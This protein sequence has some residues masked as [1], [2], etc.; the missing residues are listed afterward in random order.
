[1]NIIDAIYPR[2]LRPAALFVGLLVYVTF[3][4]MLWQ[5]GYLRLSE[6]AYIQVMV[7][8]VTGFAALL[9]VPQRWT[10]LQHTSVTL[11]RVLWTNL[12]VVAVAALVPHSLRVLLLVVPLFGVFYASLNVNR[13]HVLLI[14][15]LTWLFYM[16]CAVLFIEINQT[17]A[18]FEGLLMIGFAIMLGG[19]LLLSWE[20]LLIR[21][22]LK[23]DNEGMQATMTRLR[24]AA[25]RDE[26][27]GVHNRRYL[28][29]ALRRQKA[30]ADRG[31][32]R[33]TLCYCDLD[34]FKRVNDDFGHAV[35][36]AALRQFA[37]LAQSVV[38]NVDY[39][40]RYGGEEFILLLQ[41][42][43]AEDAER[44]A[45]RLGSKTRQMW[46]P[47]TPDDFVLTVSIGITEY[48]S[49][50]RID[51]VLNRADKALY[52]AKQAG[53]DRVIVS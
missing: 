43:G 52:R 16:L 3:T 13:G 40:A 15:I 6:T 22:T 33:F 51:D 50:E 20:A 38:R 10:S 11:M 8:W 4:W 37:Q 24:E 44:V 41:D 32:H 9:V 27:T 23:K 14:A 36:D 53:R 47:G 5:N 19:G 1:M 30:L 42:T 45:E 12:G 34:H 46:V 21:D 26:L 31:A 39:A 49:G 7:I 2:V 35:G 48:R 18:R 28:L 17:N 29:E 25:L